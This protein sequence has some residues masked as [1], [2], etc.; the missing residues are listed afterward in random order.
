MEKEIFRIDNRFVNKYY[1]LRYFETHCMRPEYG[2]F[3]S[4]I[5]GKTAFHKF[6]TII[7]Y[8]L[9]LSFRV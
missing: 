4:C 8:D 3:L 5:K 2:Y 6:I 7:I 9:K 1:P